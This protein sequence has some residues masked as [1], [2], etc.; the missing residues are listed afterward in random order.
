[1]QHAYNQDTQLINTAQALTSF[2]EQASSSDWLAVDT[3][4]F[5]EKT[6]YPQ[7][8]LVQ[9]ATA[10]TIACIDML[11][12]ENHTALAQLLTAQPVLKVFHSA[13][14]DIEALSQTLGAYPNVIFDTQI[15]AAMLG[16][17]EQISY[18]AL[19]RQLLD[20]ELPKS[21]TRTDWTQRPLSTAQLHYAADDV[22]YLRAVFLQERSELQRLGRLAWAQ[23]ESLRLLEPSLYDPDPATLL[24]KVKG[25]QQLDARQRAILQTL[26]VWRETYARRKN[27]PRKWVLSDQ[28]MLELTQLDTSTISSTQTLPKSTQKVI[29]RYGKQLLPLIQS[30]TQ[31]DAQQ[32]SQLAPPPAPTP[33]QLQQIKAWRRIVNKVSEEQKIAPSLLATRKALEQLVISKEKIPLLQGWRLEL[34]RPYLEQAE[35]ITLPR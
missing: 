30:V 11:G 4:F 26:A 32:W 7:L 27:L 16:L 20:I 1:M 14:Q 34:I 33:E 35:D 3:E 15:G 13:G 19:V 6:Y 28:A 23:E 25:Q 17:G 18:A 2:C 22:R 21:E 31:A 24:K 29:A 9:V 12:I 8:C 10:E 5:R